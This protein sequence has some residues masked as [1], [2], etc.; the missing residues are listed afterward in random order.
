MVLHC[1]ILVKVIF[2]DILLLE[3]SLAVS[4]QAY[5]YL[6]L[7]QVH[8]NVVYQILLEMNLVMVDLCD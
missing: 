8:E 2:L 1:D 3:D 5:N 4:Y 6:S 7:V